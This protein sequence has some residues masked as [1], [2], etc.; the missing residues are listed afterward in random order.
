MR[1]ACC[2]EPARCEVPESADSKG[3]PRW[4]EVGK[5]GRFEW[6]DHRMHWMGAGDPPNLT[7]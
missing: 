2:G 4:E 3:A 6:H 1:I 5:T 7:P